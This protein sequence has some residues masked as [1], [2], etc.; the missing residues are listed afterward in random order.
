MRAA[1][2]TSN[3]N[4]K[5]FGGKL[6]YTVMQADELV[7]NNQLLSEP[8]VDAVASELLKVLGFEEGKTLETSQYDL[9]FMH[10]GA[11]EKANDQETIASEIEYINGLVGRIM[12]IA[13]PESE[14]GS[15]LHLSVVM[16]YGVVL[17]DDDPSLSVLVT[18]GKNKSDLSLLFPR[19]SYTMKGGKPRDNVR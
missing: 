14:I 2:I 12:Q 18:T 16:N 7:K 1:I 15:R 8:L 10:I 13:Q 4:L 5:S 19:Q 11:G 6:G 17:E 3:S 9:V